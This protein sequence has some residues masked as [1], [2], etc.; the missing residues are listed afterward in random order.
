MAAEAV[1]PARRWAARAVHALTASGAVLGAL[2]CEAALRG[3]GPATFLWLGVAL[4]VDGADGW[5]ARR[6]DVVRAAPN[7]D[8]AALDLVVDYVTY[9]LAPALYL[10]SSDLLPEA[11]RWPAA[12]AIL[13]S[14]LYTFARRDMKTDEHDFRGFP[15]IWN[16]AAAA[17]AVADAPAIANAAAVALLCALTFSNVRVV[18]P[19]RVEAMRAVTIAAAIGWLAASAAILVVEAEGAADL[20]ARAI[21]WT[22]AAYFAVL[23]AYR[24]A[25]LR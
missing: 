24:T 8:G 15:A 13:L 12:A 11:A 23:C 16:L 10:L 1:T 3:D 19:L 6:V 2:A 22:A 7:I 9:V 25:A 21:W 4:I 5:L 20:A 14:S 18:H 17:F